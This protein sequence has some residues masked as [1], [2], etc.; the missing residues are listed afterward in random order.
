MSDRERDRQ[1][2]RML[3]RGRED[4]Q[5]MRK[6][7]DNRLHRK[8]NGETQ[9]GPD[10]EMMA[11]DVAMF[12]G[13]AA[14]ARRQEDEIAKQ[15]HKVLKRFPIYTEW[16]SRVKGVGDIAAGWILSEY[17]IHKANTVSALWQFTGLNP[18]LVRGKKRIENEDGTYS[19]VETGEYIRGDRLTPGFVAPFNKRLRTAM[20]GVLADGFLKASLRYRDAEDEAEYEATDECMRRTVGSK[21]QVLASAD[22][23]A[24]E[25]VEYKM[26]LSREEGWREESKGH[27][28]RAAKRKMIKRFLQDLYKE[29]RALE[30]LEVRPPYQEEYLGRV[31]H[32]KSAVPQ[33]A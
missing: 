25:Y 17:D 14:E 29:W 16:L 1:V 31:H 27:R 24:R 32:S 33:E 21:K 10:I 4:F 7:L 20:V 11:G 22:G 5:A 3:V 26:R 9:K 28:D 12:S 23:Y 30:G 2:V 8:A 6:R 18:G 19:Y 13:V 15:L